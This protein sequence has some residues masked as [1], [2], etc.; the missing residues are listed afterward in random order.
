MLVV[1]GDALDPDLL[2]A[3]ALRFMRRY[4]AWGRYGVSAFLANDAAEVDVLCE[5][6]LERFA[7]LVVFHREDLIASDVELV[8]TFRPARHPRCARA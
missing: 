7:T 5:T 3:D 6:R 1:R 8:P 4:P 2:R